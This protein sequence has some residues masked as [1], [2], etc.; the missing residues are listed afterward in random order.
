MVTPTATS[1][2]SSS[3]TREHIL[4]L[5]EDDD[6]D[7]NYFA[8]PSKETQETWYPTLRS[9]LWV[10]SCLHTYVQVSESVLVRRRWVILNRIE[11]LPANH[12]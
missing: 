11:N 3:R 9:T 6:E 1:H 4:S 5:D 12:L 10:L 2:L 8:L 7:P